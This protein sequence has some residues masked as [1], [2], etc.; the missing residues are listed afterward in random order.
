MEN[1][2]F[3]AYTFIEEKGIELLS[4]DGITPTTILK[5]SKGELPRLSACYALPYE[6]RENSEEYGRLQIF[7]NIDESLWNPSPEQRM[8]ELAK[9]GALI[10]LEM[11]RLKTLQQAANI[12]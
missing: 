10:V 7:P 1:P 9:A 6:Y 11:N 2:T 3:N 12:L 4:A 8:N 5:Y